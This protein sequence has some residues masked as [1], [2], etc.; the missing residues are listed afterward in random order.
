MS[1]KDIITSRRT[2]AIIVPGYRFNK[3]IA[4][5][6][7][8]LIAGLKQTGTKDSLKKCKNL[9]ERP[10]SLEKLVSNH[11]RPFIGNRVHL[12]NDTKV[13]EWCDLYKKTV[14]I[15]SLDLESLRYIDEFD[16]KN[17]FDTIELLK[18]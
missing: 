5:F 8:I 7:A 1:L 11:F 2:P 13:Q 14:I 3:N 9:L 12:S 10:S 16:S 17:G 4:L 6:S 15:R 18:Q